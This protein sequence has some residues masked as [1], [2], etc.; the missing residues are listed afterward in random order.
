MRLSFVIPTRNQARFIGQC[1]DGC[2]AQA[3]PDSEVV[4]VDGASTDHTHDVLAGYGD[5]VRWIS[6][7]DRGQS[8]AINKGVRLARGEL[9]AWINSDDYYENSRAIARLVAEFDADPR[10]DIAYGDGLRVD[11]SGN[12]IGPYR[13]RAITHV[14]EI[15]MHPASFVLQPSLV[16]RRQLFLDAGGVDESLHYTMDYELWIRMFGAARATRY[17]PEVIACARYHTDAKSIAAMGKQIREA[18]EVK[19]RGARELGL[20]PLA[21][22]RMYAGVASM[23]VYWMAVRLGLKRAA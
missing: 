13:G 2:F 19:R 11:V 9:V 3:I 18:Y 17:V 12:R 14:S 15:V 20:G 23:S 21:R 16:F 7:R 1:I 8:D 10:I 4:V 5:R 22:V 6:E